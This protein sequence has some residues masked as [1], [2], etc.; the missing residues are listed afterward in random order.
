MTV[1]EL[2][3][4]TRIDRELLQ[5]DIA[6]ATHTSICYVC[7]LERGNYLPSPRFL[8]AFCNKTGFNYKTMVES[9]ICER[10]KNLEEI[11]KSRYYSSKL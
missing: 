8:I 3:K 7:K 1:S 2:L 11:L 6:K 9:L 4:S 10:K 5:K